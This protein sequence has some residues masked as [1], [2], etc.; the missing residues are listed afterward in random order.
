MSFAFILRLLER[1]MC[2]TRWVG[3]R[4][5]CVCQ[6]V[7]SCFVSV[8]VRYSACFVGI[9]HDGC[10]GGTQAAQLI[11]TEFGRSVVAAVV[12]CPCP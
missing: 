1:A 10:F 4:P 8:V 11:D 5:M 7:S 12:A 6:R 9:D 2:G 3:R